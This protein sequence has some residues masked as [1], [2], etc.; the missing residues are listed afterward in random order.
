MKQVFH[1]G[2]RAGYGSILR[3]VPDEKFAVIVLANRTAAVM[4]RTSDAATATVVAQGPAPRE[5]ASKPFR[6][7]SKPF[8]GTFECPKTL[9]VSL[10]T[11]G[12]LQ[13]KHGFMR[14]PLKRRP[15]GLFTDSV[16]VVAVTRGEGGSVDFLHTELHTLARV[17]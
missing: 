9:K 14:A 2:G 16:L 8:E 11:L 1:A 13:M 6:D 17:K 12:V 10:Y 7:G 4:G 5:P 15:D 3:M